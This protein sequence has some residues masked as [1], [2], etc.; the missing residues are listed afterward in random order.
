V[1]VAINV[2]AREFHF[3][4]SLS[5][6][7]SRGTVPVLK[8][9][10]HQ[11]VDARLGHDVAVEWDVAHWR[12]VLDFGLPR[13]TDGGSCGLFVLA[14]AD[15]FSL[16]VP[17]LFSQASIGAV[18]RRI[19]LALFFDDLDF[20]DN[21]PDNVPD[22]VPEPTSTSGTTTPATSDDESVDKNDAV[23]E[24]GAELGV[25]EHGVGEDVGDTGSERGEVA[26]GSGDDDG[27]TVGGVGEEEV[28]GQD[29]DIED[30]GECVDSS[31]E[32]ADDEDMQAGSG[33]VLDWDEVEA[34]DEHGDNGRWR[35][36]QGD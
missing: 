14:A 15:C 30:A 17:M 4:D 24:D 31:V 29:I 20:P 10:L 7:D 12:V 32:G 9:W 8:Q 26:A 25:A 27:G 16:G 28:G 11:E 23:T 22:N 35:D 2:G 36:E 34:S 18:R 33:G 5:M 6:E 3:Y 19:T 1:L 13:Q 21:I